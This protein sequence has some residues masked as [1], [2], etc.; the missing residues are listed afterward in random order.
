MTASRDPAVQQAARDLEKIWKSVPRWEEPEQEVEKEKDEENESCFELSDE[1]A[2][3]ESSGD[4]DENSDVNMEDAEEVKI[5][6]RT[7]MAK[8]VRVRSKSDGDQPVA[9]IQGPNQE[10]TVILEQRQLNQILTSQADLA[11]KLDDAEKRAM[12]AERAYQ[13]VARN[14]Q[15]M[16]THMQEMIMKMQ[17]M[18]KENAELRRK[19]QRASDGTNIKVVDWASEMEYV[20]NNKENIPENGQATYGMSKQSSGQ[21]TRRIETV[22]IDSH[23]EASQETITFGTLRNTTHEENEGSSEMRREFQ[24]FQ[25]TVLQKMDAMASKLGL[26]A[27]V[28][29]IRT[30]NKRDDESKTMGWG[31]RPS[32]AEMARTH[33]S[34]SKTVVNWLKEPR[35]P[36]KFVKIHMKINM[37]RRSKTEPTPVIYQKVG[38]LL[39]YVGIRKQVKEVSMIGRSIVELYVEENDQDKVK[40]R[41]RQMEA[42]IIDVAIGGINPWTNKSAMEQ[43]EQICTRIAGLLRRNMGKHMREC[44]LEGIPQ[45]ICSQAL[46]ME[47]VR[48]ETTIADML[49]V[50]EQDEIQC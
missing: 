39:K 13:D 35:P 1:S 36:A 11:K 24:K 4:P 3:E 45:E 48:R 14:M 9:V 6:Q 23:S 43:Q 31:D 49:K 20:E 37:D 32:F 28:S 40:E 41:L 8:R 29:K 27:P 19:G 42:K 2:Y 17:K 38:Q 10:T 47:G 50:K 18:E 16:Q 21:E 46:Q 15:Q 26:G 7:R 30:S 44:I 25:E 5:A 22:E 12:A 34:A 33:N